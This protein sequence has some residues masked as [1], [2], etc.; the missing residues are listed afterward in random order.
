MHFITSKL[1][2]VNTRTCQGW[3]SMYKMCF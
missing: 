3:Q 2:I 1:D